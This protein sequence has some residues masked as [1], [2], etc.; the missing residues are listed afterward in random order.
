MKKLIVASCLLVMSGCSLVPKAPL[1]TDEEKVA[2]RAHQRY[3]AMIAG[4]YR[5]AYKLMSPG[6]RVLNTLEDFQA[7][8]RGVAQWEKVQIVKVTC[9]EETCK[10]GVSFD[11]RRE[12]SLRSGLQATG[13]TVRDVWGKLDGQ[14]YFLRLE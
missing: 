11:Y 10:V 9:A 7:A 4:D 2:E 13:G 6:Y 12:K 14:W 8:N 3:Q 1:A 5:K